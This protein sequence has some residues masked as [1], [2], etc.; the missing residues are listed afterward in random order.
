MGI[1]RMRLSFMLTERCEA[2]CAEA[3]IRRNL[4]MRFRRARVDIGGDGVGMFD[5]RMIMDHVG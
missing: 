2:G 3:S 4:G 5:D 1:R